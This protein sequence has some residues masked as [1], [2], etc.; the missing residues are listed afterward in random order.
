MDELSKLR[1]LE[2]NTD[3]SRYLMY[4]SV[5]DNNLKSNRLNLVKVNA[6]CYSYSLPTTSESIAYL[7]DALL[8]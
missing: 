2:N 8:L 7:W 6:T 1:K 5:Y 3:I 4:L